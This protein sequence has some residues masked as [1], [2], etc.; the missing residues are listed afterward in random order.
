[1]KKRTNENLSEMAAVTRKIKET[2]IKIS[3]N[4]IISIQKIAFSQ[5]YK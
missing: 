1:M 3:Y 4:F 2:N 5:S